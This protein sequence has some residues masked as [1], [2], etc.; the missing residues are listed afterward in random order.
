MILVAMRHGKAEPEGAGE[1][2]ARALTERGRTDAAS[3]GRQLAE[4]GVHPALALVSSAVRTRQTFDALPPEL[5]HD[6]KVRQL[7]E[8]YNADLPVMLSLVAEGENVMVVGHNPTISSF[9]AFLVGPTNLP[10][11]SMKPADAAIVETDRLEAG[12]GR[13]LAYVRP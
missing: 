3:V 13:L 8:L 6:A 11:P 7:D 10:V 1:D 12:K 9:V 5:F 2:K 4:N